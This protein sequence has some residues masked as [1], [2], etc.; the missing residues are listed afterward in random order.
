MEHPEKIPTGSAMIA[1]VSVLLDQLPRWVPM[2]DR[3]R[4]A[5][6]QAR[7]LLELPPPPADPP[8]ASAQ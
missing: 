8:S 3:V 4:L 7:K 2:G 1:L 6:A 5:N